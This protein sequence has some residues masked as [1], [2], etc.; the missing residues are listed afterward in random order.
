VF[1]TAYPPS[2]LLNSLVIR[3][4]SHNNLIASEFTHDLGQ[5]PF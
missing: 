3:R 2:F 1:F 4:I 5:Y